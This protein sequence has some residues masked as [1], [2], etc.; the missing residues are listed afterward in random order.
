[1]DPITLNI[2][3]LSL[4]A[5]FTSA[6]SATVGLGGGVILMLLMPGLLPLAISHPNPCARSAV[7]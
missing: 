7:E 6:I 5:F 1:M 2:A 3:L 4:L